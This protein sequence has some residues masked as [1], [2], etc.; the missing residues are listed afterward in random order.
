LVFCNTLSNS[1][2]D[3]FIQC[4]LKYRRQYVE[5]APPDPKQD[6]NALRFGS[7]KL[8]TVAELQTI[9]EARKSEYVFSAKKY[10]QSK[11]D[12]CITNFLRFNA[13]LAETVGA[14]LR[15]EV[16]VGPGMTVNGII[17]RVILGRDGGYLVI[18]YKTSKRE[19]TK[20]QLYNDF[21]L[22]GYAYAIAK[23][24]QVPLE[25]ITC[26]HYYPLTDTFVSI[27]YTRA[28]ISNYQKV[29]VDDIWTI[30]KLKK[31]QLC[32]QKNEFCDW[33]TY[34]YLCPLFNK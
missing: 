1:K 32:A 29:I 3:V 34:K 5:K 19:K 26:A 17:D 2:R 11:I 22:M 28:Q 30:R 7:Y 13:S 21:Q 25:K 33:C 9:A 10:P 14:E 8:D 16:E 6:V 12:T 4:R 18:D 31:E 24:F 23:M 27:K 20:T 15:Y